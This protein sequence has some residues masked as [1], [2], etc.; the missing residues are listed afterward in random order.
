MLWNNFEA[1]D[2]CM[3]MVRDVDAALQ[4]GGLTYDKVLKVFN[5][6]FSSK[7]CERVYN[8]DA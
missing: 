8:Q 6:D 2:E 5:D 7:W 3:A 1:D 4:Q